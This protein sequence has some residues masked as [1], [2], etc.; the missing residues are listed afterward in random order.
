MNDV[1]F[2][3]IS[4]GLRRG[5]LVGREA[6]SSRH[7]SA[8]IALHTRSDNLEVVFNAL[9]VIKSMLRAMSKEGESASDG[10]VSAASGMQSLKAFLSSF[11]NEEK[12]DQFGQEARIYCTDQGLVMDDFG[13]GGSTTSNQTKAMV[14]S[15]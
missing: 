14:H 1:P 9:P 4:K 8:K 3:S 15:V 13:S 12:M 10:L 6:T 5:M 7:I 2:I 11:R